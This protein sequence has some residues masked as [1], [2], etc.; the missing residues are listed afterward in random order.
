MTLGLCSIT[1][2]L[3]KAKQWML[4]DSLIVRPYYEQFPI[5]DVE[6][7]TKAE[8]FKLNFQN[9]Q[10]LLKE[11]DAA[12]G[13]TKLSPMC[14]K[15][16]YTIG[17]WLH[18]GAKSC[19][20]N[21]QGSLSTECNPRGGQ[22]QCRPGVTGRKCDQCKL[23]FFGF[24]SKGCTQCECDQQGTINAD[25]VCTNLIFQTNFMPIFYRFVTNLM[26]ESVDAVKVSVV[27]IVLNVYPDTGDSQ[28]VKSVNVTVMP[29]PATSVP[30]R[31]SGQGY[32]RIVY[33]L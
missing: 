9:E 17:A 29:P 16:T 22:C 8:E 20:C 23:G 19:D 10:C 27:V 2:I 31:T 26:V 11:L 3:F 32:F 24:S 30:V 15:M 33:P 28:I 18:D 14:E 4:V 7:V 13:L 1:Y 12:N 25:Q 21:K 5:F 6:T